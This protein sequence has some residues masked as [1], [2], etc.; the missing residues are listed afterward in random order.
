MET[1]LFELR[2]TGTFI[3]L[4]CIKPNASNNNPFEA[5]MA[6]RSGYKDSRAVIVMSLSNPDRGCTI[7]PYDW[8]S[9]T[10]HAAHLHIEAN[11]DKLKTGDL[12]DVR[13]LL[14]VTDKPCE[15]EA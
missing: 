3:P 10:Y 7:E 6:W 11:W 5:K 2:D 8:K 13:V 14:G 1:K 15:S 12:I 4:L 9:R